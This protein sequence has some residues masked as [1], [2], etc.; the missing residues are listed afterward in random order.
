MQVLFTYM[1]PWGQGFWALA[2]G[3][4]RVYGSGSGLPNGLLHR[5]L[6]GFRKFIQGCRLAWGRVSSA[7]NPPPL[8][9]GY[10]RDPTIKALKSSRFI[11]SG[12]TLGG[13]PTQ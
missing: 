10:N 6:S 5:P 2:L 4:Y 12:S 9:R 11:Y 3:S 8:N 1:D 7:A 13:L